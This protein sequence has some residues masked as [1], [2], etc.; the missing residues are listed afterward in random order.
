MLEGDHTYE[1]DRVWSVDNAGQRLVVYDVVPA[2]IA[3]ARGWECCIQEDSRTRAASDT[4]TM[5]ADR[6]YVPAV[7]VATHVAPLLDHA[8]LAPASGGGIPSVTERELD[9]L[10]ELSDVW[11][12]ELTRRQT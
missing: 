11:R 9:T 12:S 3:E 5:D 4:E 1:F 8:E 6:L 2:A 10:Q 7:H